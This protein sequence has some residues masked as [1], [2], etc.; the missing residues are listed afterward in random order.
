MFKSII[1][2]MKN[3]IAQLFSIA[4]LA[5]HHRHFAEARARP[6]F[7]LPGSTGNGLTNLQVLFRRRVANNAIF[8]PQ[9]SILSLILAPLSVSCTLQPLPLLLIPQRP[10]VRRTE[11]GL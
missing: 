2:R 3:E 5:L 1:S 9:G 8:P 7:Q 10:I 11:S 4:N 6:N